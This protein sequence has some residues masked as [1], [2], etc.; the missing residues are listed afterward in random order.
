MFERGGRCSTL[1]P[2]AITFLKLVYLACPIWSPAHHGAVP[3]G[4]R[5]PAS[6]RVL[7][8]TTKQQVTHR[9]EASWYAPGP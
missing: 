9:A 8:F 7:G 4:S 2:H 1:G 3:S 6:I 5:I